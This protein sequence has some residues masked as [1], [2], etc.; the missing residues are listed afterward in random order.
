M[1][2]LDQLLSLSLPPP[3]L[4]LHPLLY[5]HAE[6]STPPLFA[7]PPPTPRNH[8][9][10]QPYIHKSSVDGLPPGPGQTFYSA[11]VQ[12]TYVISGYDSQFPSDYLNAFHSIKSDDEEKQLRE[13]ALELSVLLS[14]FIEEVLTGAAT[15][16]TCEWQ[17]VRIPTDSPLQVIPD[18]PIIFSADQA[19][20]STS[21]NSIG[22]I[23]P[24]TF[25]TLEPVNPSTV[26]DLTPTAE[27]LHPPTLP[28]LKQV[29]V[30]TTYLNELLTCLAVNGTCTMMEE[31][32]G[33]E[34]GF[35][36]KKT[37]RL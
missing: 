12:K 7:C 15:N 25:L 10:S 8:Y 20:S 23:N 14:N 5:Y 16:S 36:T 17:S 33:M 28:G 9:P 27:V 22:Y 37:R 13:Q 32:L 21:S 4:H 26:P 24:S 30:N 6:T 35:I 31:L 34:K 3:S 2:I 11:G 1:I 19:T 29:D 18:I